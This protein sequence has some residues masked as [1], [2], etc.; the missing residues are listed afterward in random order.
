M[1]NVYFEVKDLCFAYYKQPLC[2]KDISFS[3]KEK[4]KILVVGLQ[5]MGKT[6]LLKSISGFDKTYFG[7]VKV[8]GIDIK[9]I[10]EEEKN[11]SIMFEDPVLLN[12]TVDKNIDFVCKVLGIVKS[13]EDKL[14]LLNQFKLDVGLNIKVKNL[15]KVQKLKLNFLR[16][17]LKQPKILFIDDIFRGLTKEEVQ[18][19]CC[20]LDEL[21]DNTT[22]IIVFS[23]EVLLDNE[24]L[25]TNKFNTSKVIYLNLSK[26]YEFNNYEEFIASK[27]DLNVCKFSDKFEQCEGICFMENNSYYFSDEHDIRIKFDKCF[28]EKLDVLK[29]K[30]Y[31]SDDI[32][33][34]YEKNSKL[35]LS[36]NND[37]NKAL[38]NGKISLFAKID[39]TRIL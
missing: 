33:F 36:R 11:F 31:E 2:L 26:A 12:S 37:V 23:D 6:T 14:N 18:E 1:K 5:D 24:N 8:N 35:D 17:H 32:V 13:E 25:I 27:I 10:S 19:T 15:S 4:E 22:T 3:I 34:V 29:L 39:G 16:V 28:N 30:E 7:S 20:M 38:T 9:N 21:M